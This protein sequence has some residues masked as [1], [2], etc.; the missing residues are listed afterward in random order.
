MI[1]VL[2]GHLPFTANF[3]WKIL[4][5]V[6]S[7]FYCTYGCTAQSLC[8]FNR[9]STGTQWRSLLVLKGSTLWVLYMQTSSSSRSRMESHSFLGV[10]MVQYVTHPTGKFCRNIYASEVVTFGA[11]SP[12]KNLTYIHWIIIYHC[13]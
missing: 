8:N 1:T 7:K 9:S 11:L 6:Q 3:F 10:S 4:V 2:D 13:Y 12:S 5:A